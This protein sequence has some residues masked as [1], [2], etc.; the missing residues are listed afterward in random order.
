MADLHAPHRRA[1]G[2]FYNPWLPQDRRWWEVWRWWLSRSSLGPEAPPAPAMPTLANDGA[3]LADPRARPS[4]TWIGHAS[5]AV[6]LGGPLVL[7][8]PLFGP[9]AL[10]V[11][12]Q[13]PPA[14]GPEKVPAGSLVVISHNHY[15]HL[16]A[17]SVAALAD[18]AVFLC[19]LGLGDMLRDMGA[20]QVVELDWWQERTIEGTRLVCLPAQHWSLRLGQ[21]LNQGLWCA[22]LIERDGRRVFYGGDSGYFI[23]FREIGR[24]FPGIDA[25]LLP[26][27]AYLPRW[28]MHYAHMD[29][30]EAVRAYRDLGARWLVPTQWGALKLGDEP[31]AWPLLE[32]CEARRQ[33]PDLTRG[34]VVLPQGGR[35]FLD[36]PAGVLPSDTVGCRP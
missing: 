3:Y 29:I 20:R 19:P 28:F 27:G 17:V 35:L 23:G 15:D 13:A 9:R 2:A 25:A 6:Q 18:K 5:F 16:D 34:L 12:R 1:D 21:G 33:D 24:R 32:L 11:G 31:A 8:D 22:W 30:G 36:Q 10:V 26:V 14:F 7:T 4:L